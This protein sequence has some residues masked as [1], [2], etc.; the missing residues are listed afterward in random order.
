M[1]LIGATL[2]NEIVEQKG[3]ESPAKIIENLHEQIR[4]IL[5]Q[6]DL[7][8]RDGMDL[9]LCKLEKNDTLT[10]LTYSGAKRPLYYVNKLNELE[11]IKSTHKSIG[12][13]NK[14]HIDFEEFSY[15]LQTG[16]MI[17]LTTDGYTDQNNTNNEKLGSLKFKTTLL[18]IANLEI[19][20]QY[21]KI[22]SLFDKHKSNEPQRD[23][24]TVMGIRIG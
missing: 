19:A 23:D 17:Y 21:E 13:G 16:E 4:I 12:G 24:V 5:R 20:E 3:I 14:E 6:K 15:V 9:C 2:L 7:A 8:N 18:E 10:Q 22:K 1:S 11:H